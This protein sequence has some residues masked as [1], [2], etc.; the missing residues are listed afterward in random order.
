MGKL[1]R[2]PHDD[3]FLCRHCYGLGYTSS[4]TS[5]DDL[6]QAELRFRRA[7]AK[8]DPQGRRPHPNNETVPHV[9]DRPAGM[10]HETYDALVADLETARLEWEE[11]W[12]S[13]LQ[14]MTQ[15]LRGD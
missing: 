13:R 1:Y 12:I 10:H 2:P 14:A 6:K 3:L 8:L 9:P 4:R 7:Y 11:E 5:G 15:S